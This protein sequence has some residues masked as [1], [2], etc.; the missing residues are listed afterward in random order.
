MKSI[1]AGE[2]VQRSKAL[3]VLPEDPGSIP[4]T[5]MVTHNDL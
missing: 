3:A 1:G 2:M 5:Y 4:S